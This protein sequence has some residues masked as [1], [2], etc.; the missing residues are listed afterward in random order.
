MALSKGR[1]VCETSIPKIHQARRNDPDWSS[2]TVLLRRLLLIFG[3]FKESESL[4]G[5]VYWNLA[6]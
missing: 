1:T 6:I 2:F 4:E 5:V 3:H